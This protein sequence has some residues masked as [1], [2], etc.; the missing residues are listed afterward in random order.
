M[1]VVFLLPAVIISSPHPS[2]VRGKLCHAAFLLRFGFQRCGQSLFSPVEKL[3]SSAALTPLS[4]TFYGGWEV[5]AGV[6]LDVASSLRVQPPRRHANLT[7]QNLC[8]T[9]RVLHGAGNRS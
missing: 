2:P 7:P 8:N 3:K 1:A 9:L 6:F 4:L 5:A